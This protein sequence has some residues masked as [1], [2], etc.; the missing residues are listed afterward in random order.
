MCWGAPDVGPAAVYY[1]GRCCAAE[2]L[3]QT[4]SSIPAE[5]SSPLAANAA[6]AQPLTA[7]VDLDTLY[8]VRALLNQTAAGRHYTSLYYGYNQEV[9]GLLLANSTLRDSK[10]WLALLLWQPNLQALRHRS[11]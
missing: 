7:T 10:A 3:Q 2:Y 1:N 5:L 6:P 8:S 9:L 11:G 4:Y